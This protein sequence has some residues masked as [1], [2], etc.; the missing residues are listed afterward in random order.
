MI[1]P[2][3]DGCKVFLHGMDGYGPHLSRESILVMVKNNI[4]SYVEPSGASHKCQR[5]DRGINKAFKIE[6]KNI[7]A[8]FEADLY[9]TKTPTSMLLLQVKI[10]C[11]T[12]LTL[13]KNER[14][15]K[16]IKTASKKVCWDEIM[17]ISVQADV[18]KWSDGIQY[19]DPL[20]MCPITTGNTDS[21]L[22]NLSLTL[23]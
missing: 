3:E 4:F 9:Y 17:D 2:D 8:S 15:K 13:I 22:I 21:K 20:T 1:E 12:I 18:R 10:I 14:K 11:L 7:R 23:N 5:N 6:Q 16:T 19:R